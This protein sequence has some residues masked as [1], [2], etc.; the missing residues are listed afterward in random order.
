MFLRVP[1]D[2]KPALAFVYI[3]QKSRRMQY[4]SQFTA[5]VLGL[6][7]FVFTEIGAVS[8]NVQTA[9]RAVDWYRNDFKYR[10]GIYFL[11]LT[12][13]QKRWVSIS[14]EIPSKKLTIRY[15]S[16]KNSY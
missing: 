13:N 1:S 9:Q 2:N 5:N 12:S 15:K 10:H 3:S 7:S 14:E 11:T 16:N 8:V 6:R 4:L